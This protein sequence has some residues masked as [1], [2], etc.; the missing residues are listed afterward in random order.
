MSSAREPVD[1]EAVGELVARAEDFAEAWLESNAEEA[2]G[3]LLA[4]RPYLGRDLD[5]RLL[6]DTS[7]GRWLE[8]MERRLVRDTFWTVIA[9]V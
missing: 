2:R 1:V 9:E 6:A 5:A 3:E 8:D 7:Q 4:S